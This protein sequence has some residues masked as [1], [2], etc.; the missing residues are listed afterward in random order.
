VKGFFLV[1]GI[2]LCVSGILQAFVRPRGA[3][4]NALSRIVNGATIRAVVFVMVGVVAILAGAGVV[5]LPGM[6]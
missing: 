4:E 2:V 3:K 1:S 6:P 5:P